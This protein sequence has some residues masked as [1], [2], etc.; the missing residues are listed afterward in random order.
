[1][2]GLCFIGSIFFAPIFASIP[3]WAT[4]CAL[5]L[6]SE[7]GSMVSSKQKGYVLTAA[8]WLHDDSADYADQLA[9]HWRR[10]PFVCRNDIY[11]L[12]L[13]CSLWP[14]CVSN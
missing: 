9:L 10:A 12:Q 13:Q 5:I 3:P 8:G 14:N 2:T 1:V 11:P 7:T 4:G 6:V